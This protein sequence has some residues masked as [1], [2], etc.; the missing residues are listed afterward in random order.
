MA[1]PLE[2]FRIVEL[3]TMVSGPLATLLLGDQGA[4]VIKV[5]QP[6]SGDLMRH[7]GPKRGGVTAIWT[8]A[9]RNKRSIA[10]D[11][12]SEEGRQAL[13]DLVAGADVFLQ[14]FR[15]GVVE[16]MGLGYE[17]LRRVRPDLVYVSISGFGEEGPY[18]QKRVYDPIIQALSGL[19]A[20]QADRGTLRPK[21]VRTIIPDKITAMTAAQ[22]VTA[23]LLA[24]SRSGEGQHIRL[25]M[26]DATLSFIWP[27]GMVTQTFRGGDV[28][29]PRPGRTSDLVYETADGYITASTMSDAEWE[30]MAR[31][32]GHPEWLEDERY[33]TPGG[34]VAN[35]DSRLEMV[36]E[37]LR[38]DTSDAWIRKLE[39][40][41]VPC[42]KILSREEVVADPQVAVNGL[43]VEED[44]PQAGPIR[45]ARPAARFAATP[46]ATRRPAP[47]L[48]EH[49]DEVLGEIGYA[50]DR[51]AALR[52]AGA[53]A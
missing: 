27:E 50:A 22:A 24:R 20:I 13:L 10:L 3:A 31:A 48:G 37:V 19:A 43:L 36:G 40:E 6:G 38:G 30:G 9:N 1:G 4:D 11:L 32:T 18:A 51:I 14:N 5:E 2:G 41:D 23:A 25:A 21:M 8:T 52:R 33:D 34:R 44:H 16:R 47:A 35:A 46:T 39:A 17:A 15:P 26:L 45:Y 7:L 12:K 28:A 29:D 49:T 42:A 53:V